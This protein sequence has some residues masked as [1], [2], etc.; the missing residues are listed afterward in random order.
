MSDDDLTLR[1][2]HTLGVAEAKRR[3]ES[4]GASM[5]AQYG[6]F[7]KDI[8]FEWVENRM[9]FSV[10]ALM[11]TVL[12]SIDVEDNYIELRAQLPPLLRALTRR[13]LPTLRETGAK[14]L[15]RR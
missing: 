14:L 4:S 9:T 10:N 5:Q 8:E 7:L 15:M 13:F 2:P 11:Q 3:I 6:K 12:G 1:I